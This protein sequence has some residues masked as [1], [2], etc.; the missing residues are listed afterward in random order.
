MLQRRPEPVR[1]VPGQESVWD[2]PR[3]PRI[4]RSTGLVEVCLA[5]ELVA[6]TNRSLRVCETASPPSY[7]V[8]PADVA[9]EV[10]RPGYGRSTCE[11]KGEARYW[12]VVVGGPPAGDPAQRR[13]NA[14]WSYPEPWE[15]FE[16]LADWVGFYPGLVECR[17]DGELVRPQ[18]GDFY[19]G[20][21]TE[22]IVGPWKGAPGTGHW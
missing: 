13:D 16:A 6:R 17:L 11:F 14:A 9:P 22:G 4:E 15:G 20:W 19:G 8:C 12:S 3:P 7:Y 10:L 5:G 18:E 1:P 21:V 2:Y